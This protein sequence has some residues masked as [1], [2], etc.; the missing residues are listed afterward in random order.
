MLANNCTFVWHLWSGRL[1]ANGAEDITH[2]AKSRV[3]S[4]LS[5]VLDVSG[6]QQTVLVQHLSFP[7]VNATID[8]LGGCYLLGVTPMLVEVCTDAELRAALAHEVAHVVLGH[9]SAW[10][11]F[12]QNRTLRTEQ[13]ADA[14]A[15]TWLAKQECATCSKS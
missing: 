9:R 1:I 6:F 11:Q 15:V 4:A 10:S 5:A 14:V 13:E 12:G 3:S 2:L 7:G 8:N